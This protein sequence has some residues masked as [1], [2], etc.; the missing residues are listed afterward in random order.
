MNGQMGKYDLL[1]TIQMKEVKFRQWAEEMKEW[2]SS[3][4][5]A[6]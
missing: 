6:N 3:E 1:N 2:K 5:E 4:I